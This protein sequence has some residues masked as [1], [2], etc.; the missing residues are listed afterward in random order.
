MGVTVAV[1]V[2][3]GAAVGAAAGS[4]QGGDAI[5]QGALGG[6][7]G[8]AV[9][10]GVGGLVGGGLGGAIAGGAAGGLLGGVTKTALSGGNSNDYLSSGLWGAALGGATGGLTYGAGQALGGDSGGFWGSS[11]GESAGTTGTTPTTPTIGTEGGSAVVNSSPVANTDVSSL[12]NTGVQG[13]GQGTLSNTSATTPSIAAAAP[14]A[15]PVAQATGEQFLPQSQNVFGTGG[16]GTANTSLADMASQGA[17]QSQASMQALGLSSAG[18]GTSYPTTSSYTLPSG[19]TTPVQTSYPG[20]SSSG[21]DGFLNQL[22]GGKSMGDIG[23]QLAMGQLMSGG[24]KTLGALATAPETS[25]NRQQLMDLYNQQN[26]RN[27]QLANTYQQTLTNPQSYLNNP[28]A[29]A[30]RSA[31]LQAAIRSAAASG[32]RSQYP[33]L[34]SAMQQ[35]QLMDLYK[36]RQSLQQPQYG[37]AA[38]TLNYAQQYSPTADVVGGLSSMFT[39]LSA[40]YLLR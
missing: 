22:F 18:E 4:A 31:A 7:V 8:G 11:G 12:T 6:A 36:Y 5:W 38:Q 39:P 27:Q 29:A 25:Q 32:R 3:V 2:A 34:A 17:R 26:Q 28:E 21:N 19:E 20:Q 24:M 30:T 10:P 1:S 16:E 37:T 14:T 40:A 35:Q 23:K 33:A 13:A 15:T 9:A